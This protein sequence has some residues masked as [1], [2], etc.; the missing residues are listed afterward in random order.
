M[1]TL[2]EKE[3]HNGT[4]KKT[5]KKNSSSKKT[6][7]IKNTPIENSPFYVVSK[8]D[9]HFVA[10]GKYKITEEKNTIEEAFESI[11]KPNWNTIISVISIVTENLTE[12]K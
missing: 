5:S 9:K 7:L 4:S 1:E 12:N 6:E 11:E 8:D 2:T 10:F 3:N